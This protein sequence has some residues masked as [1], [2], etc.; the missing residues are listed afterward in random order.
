MSNEANNFQE[1]WENLRKEGKQTAKFPYDKVISF[2]FRNYPRDIPKNQV[3]ILEVGCGAGNNLWA[4]AK[5]GFDVYGIEGSKT[6]IEFAEKEFSK[7]GVSAC[8]YYQDFTRDYPFEDNFF[9]LIFDRCSLTYV[10][11][12]AAALAIQQIYRVLKQGSLFFFN[13]YSTVHFSFNIS[14][15]IFDPAKTYVNTTRGSLAGTGKVCFYNKEMIYDMF[16]NS[17]W[18]IKQ[19]KHII[20]SDCIDKENIHAEWEVVLKKL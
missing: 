12:Q 14:G 17:L 6:A 19:L 7:Y 5:E 18:E 15:E 13:P 20:I 2:V 8:L 3:K 9:D 1:L 16:S 10:S 4:L 11:Y